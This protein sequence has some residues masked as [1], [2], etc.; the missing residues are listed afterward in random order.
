MRKSKVALIM[1]TVATMAIAATAC[2]NKQAN[3]TTAAADSANS[4]DVATAGDASPEDVLANDPVTNFVGDDTAKYTLILNA[5]PNDM[6]DYVVSY[7]D[8]ICLVKSSILTD[9]FGFTKSDRSNDEM[10]EYT[11]KDG[12]ILQLMIGSNDIIF[13]GADNKIGGTIEKVEGSDDVTISMDFLLCI[14][15]YNTYSTSVQSDALT[16]E[17]IV[18]M[19]MD[20]SVEP[21]TDAN[22]EV[23]MPVEG[24]ETLGTGMEASEDVLSEIDGADVETPEETVEAA[25]DSQPETTA[26]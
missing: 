9:F 2:A 1:A 22:G 19:P 21:E 25:E 8:G 7:K 24:D 6:T 12:K 16:F 17:P 18:N 11:N 5:E 20:Y 15:E 4:T 10:V 13:D 14:G 26:E 3:S 23:I